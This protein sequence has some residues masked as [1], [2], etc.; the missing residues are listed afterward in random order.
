MS[1]LLPSNIK[2]RSHLFYYSILL[3]S[4]KVFLSDFILFTFTIITEVLRELCFN[5]VCATSKNTDQSAHTR[6]QIRAFASRLK[7]FTLRQLI[8]ASVQSQGNENGLLLLD[9]PL[10]QRNPN[11]SHPCSV[12]IVNTF[13]VHPLFSC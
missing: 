9:I 7:T 12:F 2:V 4:F 10:N 8:F 1:I 11:S 5:V 6:S 3:S 13:P